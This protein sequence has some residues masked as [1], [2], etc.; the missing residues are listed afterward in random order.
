ML[1]AGY[2]RIYTTLTDTT[3]LL[4]FQGLGMGRIAKG[5]TVNIWHSLALEILT[6]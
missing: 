1:P 2:N 4:L 5:V 6:E 3:A